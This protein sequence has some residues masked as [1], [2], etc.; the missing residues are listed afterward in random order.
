VDTDAKTAERIKAETSTNLAN[1]KSMVLSPPLF[2]GHVMII[3]WKKIK[4]RIGSS[5]PE[6]GLTIGDCSENDIYL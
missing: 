5:E 2:F 1:L 3:S 4:L 6:I